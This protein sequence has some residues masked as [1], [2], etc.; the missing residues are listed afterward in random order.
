VAFKLE[1]GTAFP[2]CE[3]VRVE[4]SSFNGAIFSKVTDRKPTAVTFRLYLVI[5]IR[6]IESDPAVAV[7]LLRW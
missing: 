6:A 5:R 3:V 4:R 7:E 1:A 2:T